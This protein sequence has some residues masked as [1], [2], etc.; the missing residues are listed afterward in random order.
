MIFFFEDQNQAIF[1]MTDFDFDG[2]PSFIETC[3][4]VY[5]ENPRFWL[6]K[7]QCVAFSREGLGVLD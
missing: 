7:A 1:N 2:G 3:F 5:K 4:L 6:L